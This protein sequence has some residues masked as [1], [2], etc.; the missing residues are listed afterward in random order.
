MDNPPASPHQTP[1]PHRKANRVSQ[2]IEYSQNLSTLLP[3]NPKTPAKK[4]LI[5]EPGP[6]SAAN[7]V[8]CPTT[9]CETLETDSPHSDN[10]STAVPSSLFP[11]KSRV[12]PREVLPASSMQD[13]TMTIPITVTLRAKA[14]YKSYRT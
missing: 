12:R 6:S 2:L 10:N 13:F 3:S 8:K 11:Q 5:I 1:L 4:T 7:L 9:S 14:C